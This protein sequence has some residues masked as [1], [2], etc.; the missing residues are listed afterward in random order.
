[1]NK[2][3]FYATITTIIFIFL[4][5]CT[6]GTSNNKT[7]ENSEASTITVTDSTDYSQYIKRTWFAKNGIDDSL[8]GTFSFYISKIDNG[9]ITGKF[10]TND[11]IVPNY[12]Y[13]P[14]QSDKLGDLKGTINNGIAKCHFSE[15]NG[16]KGEIELNFKSKDEIDATIKFTDKSHNTNDLH[17]DGTFQFKPY[18]IKDIEGFTPFADQ[19]FN[20]NLDSWGKV[21]FVSG[22][23]TGLNHLPTVFYLTD[24]DENILYDFDSP[25]PYYADIKAVSFEDLNNDGLKDIIIIATVDYQVPVGKGEPIAEVYLQSSDGSFTRDAKLVS[26]INT[27]GNNKDVQSVKDFLSKVL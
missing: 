1:M 16:N 24:N 9:E 8:D 15:K 26:Q 20:V 2:K 18:N 23:I 12:Y 6:E 25:L 10:V 4:T 21:K 5:G 19:C 22:I 13:L 3:L 14:N 7:Q 27:S 11:L 17:K